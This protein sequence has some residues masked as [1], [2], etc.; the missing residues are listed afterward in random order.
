MN[1]NDW[2]QRIETKLDRIAE[3]LAGQVAREHITLQD[4]ESLKKVTKGL[5]E[6]QDR[7]RG[8]V[9]LLTI[10]GVLGGIVVAYVEAAR[11]LGGRQ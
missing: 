10:M 11:F 6:V 9:N 3:S 5:K 2:A 7:Q 8:A 4:V 1:E